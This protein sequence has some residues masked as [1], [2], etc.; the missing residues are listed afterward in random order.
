MSLEP[1][2]QI[3]SY[4]NLFPQTHV[5]DIFVKLFSSLSLKIEL[6]RYC[7]PNENSKN[8]NK[9]PP[10]CAALWLGIASAV[11][12]LC[13]WLQHPSEYSWCFSWGWF[14]VLNFQNFLSVNIWVIKADTTQQ[15]LQHTVNVSEELICLW[16]QFRRKLESQHRK[17]AHELLTRTQKCKES[18]S[19]YFDLWRERGTIWISAAHPI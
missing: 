4:N 2:D 11:V 13:R 1:L 7:I 19:V 15:V 5:M 3:Y 14:I 10:M 12:R 6:N 8:S 17:F 18:R 9:K 16:I